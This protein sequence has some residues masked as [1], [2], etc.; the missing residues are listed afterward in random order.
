[1]PGSPAE[2]VIDVDL[3]KSKQANPNGGKRSHDEQHSEDNQA[4]LQ[5]G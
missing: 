1:L 2:D 4:D 3:S 5:I